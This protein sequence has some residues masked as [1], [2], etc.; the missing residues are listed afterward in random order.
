MEWDG[1]FLELTRSGIHLQAVEDHIMWVGIDRSGLITVNNIYTTINNTIWHSNI[2]G[3]RI[4]F[5]TWKLPL[6]IKLFNWI[7]DENKIPT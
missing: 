1:C 7:A 5:W 6:K 2:S 4:N 3:W